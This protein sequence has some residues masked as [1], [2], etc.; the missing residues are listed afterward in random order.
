MSGGI[1][2]F[3][4][5]GVPRIREGVHVNHA[6]IPIFVEQQANKTGPNKTC[7]A[8]NE[9]SFHEINSHPKIAVLRYTPLSVETKMSSNCN[10]T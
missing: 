6:A 8:G 5:I 7:A 2:S 4:V 3:E 1:E 10:L 9:K